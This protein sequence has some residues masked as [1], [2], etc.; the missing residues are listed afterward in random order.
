MPDGAG[1]VNASGFCRPGVPRH[2]D[3][4]WGP[5]PRVRVTWAAALVRRPGWP[6]GGQIKRAMWRITSAR[7]GPRGLSAIQ[8]PTVTDAPG[9]GGRRGGVRRHGGVIVVAAAVT[10]FGC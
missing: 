7:L 1:C 4:R 8:V 5:G 2:R 6:I 3:P 10:V 9:R